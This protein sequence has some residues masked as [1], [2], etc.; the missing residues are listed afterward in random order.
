MIGL[1]GREIPLT[2]L[3]TGPIGTWLADNDAKRFQSLIPVF[4]QEAVDFDLIQLYHGLSYFP[5]N[6]IGRQVAEI[7]KTR[8]KQRPS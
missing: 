3:L 4:D 5:P 8:I 1:C 2:D 6:S 7:L